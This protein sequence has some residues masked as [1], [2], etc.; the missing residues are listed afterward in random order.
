MFTA[1]M[2]PHTA[3]HTAGA[4]SFRCTVGNVKD[5]AFWNVKS[6]LSTCQSSVNSMIHQTEP[7]I[8]LIEF[9]VL[10]TLSTERS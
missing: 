6:I 8:E 5:I 4:P 10:T 1:F 9:A 7:E 3:M 2:D